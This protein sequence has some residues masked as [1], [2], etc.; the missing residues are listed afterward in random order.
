MNGLTRTQREILEFILEHQA[1]HGTSPPL[2][3]I[4]KKFGMASTNGAASHLDALQAKGYISRSRRGC[5]GVLV[6]RRPEEHDLKL[7]EEADRP[8]RVDIDKS[9]RAIRLRRDG[10]AEWIVRTPD[11]VRLRDELSVALGLLEA[12]AA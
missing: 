12:S 4:C 9:L 5:H 2:R 1:K 6:L 7:V 11:A 10:V 8:V 3:A